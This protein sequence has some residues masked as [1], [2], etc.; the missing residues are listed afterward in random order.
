VPKRVTWKENALIS[1]KLRDD[2]FTIA[3]MLRRPY[4]RLFKVCNKDGVWLNL[5]LN[6]VDILFCVPVGRVVRQQLAEGKVKDRSV[7]PSSLPFPKLW[8]RPYLNFDGGF[9]FIGARLI[10]LDP[11]KHMETTTAPIVKDWLRPK[12]DAESIKKYELT[13]MW[14]A[15][16][17][18][19]RL[20]TYFDT[21]IDRDELKEKV[22]DFSLRGNS[23]TDGG[24]SS[25]RDCDGPPPGAFEREQ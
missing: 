19:K 7:I 14:G 9:P 2:L 22:F 24:S 3:Q 25:G 13:N 11:A 5:D 21:G 20:V 15:D 1:L 12:A 8:M 18:R 6:R 4:L 10:E 17:L 16:D 23:P